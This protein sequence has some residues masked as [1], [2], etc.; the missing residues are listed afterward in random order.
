M[1][2]GMP[3]GESPCECVQICVYPHE[4][5]SHWEM[6]PKWTAQTNLAWILALILRGTLSHGDALNTKGWIL[7]LC[8]EGG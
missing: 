7:S 5:D 8:L 4:T 3:L 1:G 2:A 6:V